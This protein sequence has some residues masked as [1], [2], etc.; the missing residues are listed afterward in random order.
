MCRICRI[1]GIQEQHYNLYQITKLHNSYKCIM[2][3]LCQRIIKINHFLKILSNTVCNL[4]FTL[5]LFKIYLQ[6]NHFKVNNYI[7]TILSTV[8]LIIKLP[9]KAVG[10][11]SS[12]L[13]KYPNNLCSNNKFINQ[14]KYHN[15]NKMY[16]F[17]N[18]NH[19]FSMNSYKNYNCN[20]SNKRSKIHNMKNQ[21]IHQREKNLRKKMLMI[22]SNR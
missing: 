17:N 6:F 2:Q 3:E 19:K 14:S 20:S 18:I 21:K 1:T 7:R 9:Y 8:I 13:Y 12:K 4:V 15:C 10:T 5:P 11:C 22:L 16:K